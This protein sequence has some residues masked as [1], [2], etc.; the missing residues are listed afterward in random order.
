MDGGYIIMSNNG[1][2]LENDSMRKIQS[3]LNELNRAVKD[4]N[5]TIEINPEV[6]AVQKYQ[7][8]S[9]DNV[10]EDEQFAN[11]CEQ[12]AALQFSGS[13]KDQICEALEIEPKVYKEVVLSQEFID[14]K[15]RIAEDNK[16]N[17]LSKILTQVDGAI[18]ALSELLETADEDRVKLNAAALV[19]EHA[20]RLLEE[21]KAQFPN[22]GNIIKDAAAG[23][24]PVSLTL[25]QVILRQREER[26]LDK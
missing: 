25:A 1:K 16:V 10:V 17:I 11:L 26:G 14:I 3:K 2:K 7:N 4:K 23:S 12:V 5:E 8:Q 19:L 24:E 13:K 18:I 20:S 9:L 15:R 22:I 21:Q 6:V